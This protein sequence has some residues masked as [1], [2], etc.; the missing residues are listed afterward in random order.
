MHEISNSLLQAVAGDIEK[1]LLEDQEN[2][3]FAFKTPSAESWFR[4][5]VAPESGF[6]AELD[7][8]MFRS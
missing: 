7:V 1:L 4:F 5:P 3:A 6:A 2:I 8:L